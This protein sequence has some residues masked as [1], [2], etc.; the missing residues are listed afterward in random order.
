MIAILLHRVSDQKVS[1][2]WKH[3]SVASRICK[4]NWC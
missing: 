3:W 4:F 1:C 2:W